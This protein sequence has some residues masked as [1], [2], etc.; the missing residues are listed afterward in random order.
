MQLTTYSAAIILV[1][2]LTKIN[3]NSFLVIMR[4]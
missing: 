3:E 1:S 2:Y 4:L